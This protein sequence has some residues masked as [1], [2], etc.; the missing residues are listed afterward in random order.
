M[1]IIKKSADIQTEPLDEDTDHFKI[2]DVIA[3]TEGAPM[4]GGLVELLPG[5]GVAI[6]YDNDAAVCFMIEG[7]IELREGDTVSR[8]EPGD[9]VYIPQQAG[10]IVSWSTPSYGKFYFVTYP[11]WR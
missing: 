4:T 7:E 6:D 5:P 9:V 3:Q 11:H 1:M 8:F 2:V 10:L